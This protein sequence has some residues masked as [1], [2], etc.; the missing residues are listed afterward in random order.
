MLGG[1]REGE[2]GGITDPPFGVS[3][4]ASP[5]LVGVY[6][7]LYR[8]R[9]GALDITT[10]P[11]ITPKPDVYMAETLGRKARPIRDRP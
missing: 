4:T 7:C 1:G 8:V 9:E 3:L 11:G 10:G 5:T 2:E 6:I